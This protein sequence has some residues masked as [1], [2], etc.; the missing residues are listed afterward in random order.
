MPGKQ[1]RFAHSLV[2]KRSLLCL[3]RV[4]RSAFDGEAHALGIVVVARVLFVAVGLA[5]D[6]FGI[7]LVFSGELFAQ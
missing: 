4:A 1:A 7:G 3:D 2:L 6:G 5:R